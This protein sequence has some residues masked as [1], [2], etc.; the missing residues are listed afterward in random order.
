[1]RWPFPSEDQDPWY[2]AFTALVQAMDAAAYAGRED[3]NIILTKGGDVAF[4]AG[5]NTLTWSD[6]IEI[7]SPNEGFIISIKGTSSTPSYSLNVEDGELIFFQIVRAP[8]A[9]TSVFAFSG[10]QVNN[11]DDCILLGLRRGTKIYF[12]D[13]KVLNDGESLP[14]FDTGGGGSTGGFGA[15]GETFRDF[16]TI[17]SNQNTDQSSYQTVGAFSFNPTEFDLT[18]VTTT[19]KFRILGS[20]T[21]GGL[22]G[23]I[24]L[25]NLTDSTVVQTISVT[26]LVTTKHDVTLSGL[27]GDKV[28]EVRIKVT[29]GSTSADRVLSLWAGLV[30]DRLIG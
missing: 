8:T 12:R 19:I 25:F 1:M 3:R 26:E 18:R 17:T 5:T 6:E 24:Q 15:D 23:S 16:I 9:S 29:G 28:Y 27:T 11:S 2:G 21:G 14:I 22:T 10:S 4:D 7:V 30:I 20:V 13:G